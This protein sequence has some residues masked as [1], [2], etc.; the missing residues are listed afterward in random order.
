MLEVHVCIAICAFVSLKK[1]HNPWQ[2]LL[3]LKTSLKKNGYFIEP[4]MPAP[5]CSQNVTQKIGH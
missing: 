3:V 1:C 5:L 4:E 2:K